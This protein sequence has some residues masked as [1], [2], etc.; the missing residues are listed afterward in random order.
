MRTTIPLTG[1]TAVAALALAA[2]GHGHDR[3]LV[4][5]PAICQDFSISIYFDAGSARLT[6]EAEQLL[7]MAG[8]RTATC[9]VGG[10]QVVG[11]ADA[12]GD[13]EANLELSR[14]RA[15]T[16]TAAL[17][18]RR[19]ANVSF[20]VS[21]GGDVGAQTPSGAARPLRRRADVLFHVAPRP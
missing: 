6:S 8:R 12:P 2:C 13:P 5:T 7:R 18:R 4:E 14:R 11:L 20:D 9:A 3:A 19:F 1:A 17:A 16:V 10:V 15:A 21:A